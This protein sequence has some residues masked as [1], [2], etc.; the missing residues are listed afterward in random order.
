MA[1][2]FGNIRERADGGIAGTVRRNFSILFSSDPLAGAEN[3]S[4][5]GASFGVTLTQPIAIPASALNCEITSV[6][7]SIW[8][9][10]PNISPEFGNNIF[11]YTTVSAPA[12]TFN[13][14]IDEG[15]YSLDGL[16]SFLSARFA[17]NGHNSSLFTFA[18]NE[19]TQTVVMTVLTAGDSANFNVPNSVSSILGFNPI[20]YTA[21]SALFN[22]FGQNI[23]SF[24]RV[25][26]YVIASN[27]VSSGVPVNANARGIVAV[28]PITV[29]PG[30]QINYGPNNL[31]WADAHEL[32]GNS[33]R[34]FR[35]DL[36]DQSLRPA[37]TA[38]TWQVVLSIRYDEIIRSNQ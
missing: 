37:P 19:A 12:G 31:I 34:N 36:L 21:P 32:I 11:N 8:N 24:N 28:V 6:Q 38:E 23:A 26:S 25:N 35:F 29:P 9:T 17:N 20:V 27:I 30:S 22:F 18:G 33:V 2:R 7:A 14:A 15:L 4:P 16:Q 13:I 5:N 1:S 3:V 10:S